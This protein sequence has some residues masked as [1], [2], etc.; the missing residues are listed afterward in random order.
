MRERGNLLSVFPS[1]TIRQSQPSS[2]PITF[3]EEAAV[4]GGGKMI[5]KEED[6]EEEAA[7]QQALG[8]WLLPPLMTL[9]RE[10]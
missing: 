10:C 6:D 7:A 1:M 2:S 5:K 9:I 3:T 8:S 4:S